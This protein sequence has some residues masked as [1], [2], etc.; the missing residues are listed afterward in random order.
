[1]CGA[2]F[3][4]WLSA[5]NVIMSCYNELQHQHK[6]SAFDHQ[7]NIDNHEKERVAYQ[8][9]IFMLFRIWREQLRLLG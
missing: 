2:F 8:T 4:L 9:N 5:R 1:M 3:G 6:Q 7:H